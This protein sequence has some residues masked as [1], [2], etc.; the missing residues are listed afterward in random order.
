M[1][2]RAR[3]R[4]FPSLQSRDFQGGGSWSASRSIDGRRLVHGVFFRLIIF[5]FLS[6]TFF[7]FSLSVLFGAITLEMKHHS[8]KEEKQKRTIPRCVG[9]SVIPLKTIPAPRSWTAFRSFCF[10]FFEARRTTSS[11]RCLARLRPTGTDVGKKK[12]LCRPSLRFPRFLRRPGKDIFPPSSSP[13]FSPLVFLF[14]PFFAV[15]PPFCRL[16]FPS[17]SLFFFSPFVMVCPRCWGCTFHP[18]RFRSRIRGDPRFVRTID[19][20]RRSRIDAADGAR[21]RGRPLE[22]SGKVLRSPLRS[23]PERRIPFGRPTRLFSTDSRDWN[24]SESPP[25]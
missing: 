22:L 17:L 21:S 5:F 24:P 3:D 20:R 13:F 10:G 25:L 4:P 6:S 14:D 18:I 11:P 19:R 1:R 23:R 12:T 7:F 16:R 9:A 2:D 8:K 15:F